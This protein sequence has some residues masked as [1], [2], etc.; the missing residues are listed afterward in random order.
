MRHKIYMNVLY[1]YLHFTYLQNKTNNP[2]QI[3]NPVLP[4]A[5]QASSQQL[6]QFNGQDGDESVN[7]IRLTPEIHKSK[8]PISRFVSHR[9]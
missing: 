6:K 1:F 7:A 2:K 8:K 4:P 5:Q 3:T 9:A